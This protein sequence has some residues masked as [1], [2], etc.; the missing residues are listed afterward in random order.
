MQIPPIPPIDENVLKFLKYCGYKGDKMPV[1]RR[2]GIRAENCPVAAGL[3]DAYRYDPVVNICVGPST[4]TVANLAINEWHVYR[5]PWWL[6]CAVDRY[7]EELAA[8]CI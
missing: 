1:N 6:S 8:E 2:M 5:L 4:I 3:R 7:D